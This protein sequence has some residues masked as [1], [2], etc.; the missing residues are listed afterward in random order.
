MNWNG[1]CRLLPASTLLAALFLVGCGQRQPAGK[2]TFYDRNIG[3]ILTGSCSTSPTKSSCHVR[4]DSHGNALGNLDTSSYNTLALRRDLFINHGP[5]GL[6]E[7]LLKVVKPYQL[8]LSSYDGKTQQITTNVAHSGRALLD[9]TSGSFTTL[10]RWIQR[11]AQA[12]NAQLIHP[13]LAFSACTTKVGSDKLFDPTKDPSTKDYGQ[14]VASVNNVLGTRCANGNCHGSPS[15]SLYLTCGTSPEQKRWNYF[16]ASDYVSKDVSASDILRRA[17]APEQGGAYHEGGTI[18]T[19]PTDPDYKALVKWANARGGPLH[20]PTDAGFDFFAKR[21]QPMLVKR[22]CMQLGCHSPAMGHEYRL[23]GGS[24]GHFGV[25]TTRHNY[26]LTLEQ[27]ALD[28]PDPNASRIIQKNLPPTEGGLVHRGGPLLASGGD[29][30]QCDLNAAATGDLDQQPEYCVLVAWIEKERADRMASAAPLSGIV[31]VKRPPASGPDTPQDYST[32]Q[33]GADLMRAPASLD[34]QGAVQVGGAGTSLLS[35]CG[36]NA[37]TADVRRPA[38]SWDGKKIAFAARSSASEGLKI[39]VIDGTSCAPDPLVNAAPKDDTGKPLPTNGEVIHNFDPAFAPDGRMVFASTRGNIMNT[40]VFDYQGPQRSPADPSKPNANLYVVDNGK[41]RQLTFLLNQ[42]LAPSFMNDGR[43]IFTTEKRA[44]G[45]YQLAGRRENLDGGDYHP[46][47]G[48]RDTIGYNQLMNVVELSN[49]DFAAIVSEKGAEHSA[50][51]LALVNRSV[52]I[53]QH[54]DNPKDYL[55]DPTA[56]DYPNPSFYQHSMSLLD[57]AA[58]GKLDKTQGAYRDPSPLPN[59]QILVSYA[60]NVKDLANFKGNFDIFSIDPHTG[61]RTPLIS[62]A[63]D[64]IWPVAVY[65]HY[66]PHGV[67]QSKLDEPNGATHVYTTPDRKDRSE[68]TVLD[69]P[70]LASLVFQNTRSGRLMPPD[71]TQVQVWEDLPPAK[72]IK[73]VDQ[74]GSFLAQDQYGKMYV[75]R[76]PLGSMDILDDGS[77]RFEIPGGMPIVLST[78]IQLGGDSAPTTHFQR[79]EMQ[80]YP[81]EVVRQGFPHKLFNGLCGNCHGAV[82]GLE[83]HVAINPDILTQASK[84]AARNAAPVD[85]VTKAKAADRGPPFP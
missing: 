69:M 50:G 62:D 30:S 75:R 42:E 39:Y 83:S 5:Y 35:M 28:S 20:V 29:P 76:R 84:V 51:A 40:G 45:F 36:L 61:Q 73:S 8:S 14:F 47:F 24:G 34:A 15:N 48:Q 78:T 6:P 65:A 71:T 49:K 4:A 54:S 2:T 77:T 13:K 63:D 32:Y 79:E 44:P 67:Y 19:A 25:G 17:L 68:I 18:F 9:L 66:N 64:L 57:P 38:V 80:F 22:G 82:S 31:Y 16:A 81:G 70:L 72:G 59:A 11:G 23:Q 12:N 56:V 41:I 3:P 46:L 37:S 58:T 60:A 27:I 43:L 74:S 52:G 10:S 33:P 85:M 26:E 7:L 21:V 1:A 55:Q 53:D